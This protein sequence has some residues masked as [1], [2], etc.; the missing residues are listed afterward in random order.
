MGLSSLWLKEQG[1][2]SQRSGLLQPQ[3]QRR[4]RH[5]ESPG[6]GE[7]ELPPRT[8]WPPRTDASWGNGQL[9]DRESHGLLW[10]GP[11]QFCLATATMKLF[12]ISSTY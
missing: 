2:G 1:C 4:A 3:V 6:E 12:I 5:G 11:G 8:P 10:D 9:G 7:A